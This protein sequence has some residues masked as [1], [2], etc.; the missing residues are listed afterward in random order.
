MLQ[1]L[2]ISSPRVRDS[3]SAVAFNMVN[4]M[5]QRMN[6]SGEI[7]KLDDRQFTLVRE[8]VDYYKKIRNEISEVVPF[9]PMGILKYGDG[10]LCLGMK[11]SGHIR[12]ALWRMDGEADTVEIPLEANE[13][14]I[15]YPLNSECKVEKK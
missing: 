9:Y 10:W 12:L 13:V 5:L 15:G 4:A 11:S 2:T 7:T 8:C 1:I 3:E 6:L 14:K